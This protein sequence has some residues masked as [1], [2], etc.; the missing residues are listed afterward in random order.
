MFSDSWTERCR[1]I[2]CNMA[3]IVNFGSFICITS[4][5]VDHRKDFYEIIMHSA[6]MS[7]Q[8]LV[9]T[10]RARLN[11]SGLEF[12]HGS[13][14]KRPRC[15]FLSNCILLHKWC[16]AIGAELDRKPPHI[17]LELVQRNKLQTISR[18]MYHFGSSVSGISLVNWRRM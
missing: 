11:H 16:V 8:G 9:S 4:A 7:A 1:A 5:S 14:C 15:D 2:W 13:H 10:T 3:S 6:F 17:S 12:D 18:M